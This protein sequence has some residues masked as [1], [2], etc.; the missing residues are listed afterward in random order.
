MKSLM[1][2]NARKRRKTRRRRS[3]RNPVGSTKAFSA[4]FP[5]SM[6]RKRRTTRRRRVLSIRRYRLKGG[7]A[8]VAVRAR[9]IYV[10]RRGRKSAIIVARNPRRRRSYRMNP[11][12][13]NILSQ[14]K[15]VFSKENLTVAGGG[16]AATILTNYLLSM[17]KADKTSLLPLGA[18][19]DTQ[20]LAR[21]A[22]AVGIPVVGA[23]LTRKMNPSLAKG[24]VFG[25][26][27]NGIVEGI[28]GY[29]PEA[30]KKALGFAEYLDYTPM[31]AVGQ[32][33]GYSAINQFSTV[34][35]MNSAFSNSSAFPA[36][37]W[38]R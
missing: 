17:T 12:G 19:A 31:S 32:T 16:V 29:A 34:R 33:P 8:G 15:G 36:D 7:R 13:G 11:L 24:M 3:R 4:N 28:K 1:L 2:L 20:K 37:A 30:T 23:I 27:I 5:K 25:A 38:G 6:G 18:T 14:V 9:K 21:I 22:Y 26:L 35:P 10:S